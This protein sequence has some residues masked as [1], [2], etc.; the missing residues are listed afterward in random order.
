[1]SLTKE[2]TKY[3]EDQCKE[4]TQNKSNWIAHKK[5]F[6]KKRGSNVPHITGL[7]T[8]IRRMHMERKELRV[9]YLLRATFL[10]KQGSFFYHEEQVN[11]HEAL[12]YKGKFIE[13]K[14]IKKIRDDG[15][16]ALDNKRYDW[17]ETVKNDRF[18]YDRR[19]AVNYAERWWDDYNP[20]FKHF[21]VDCTNFVSQALYAGGA[22]MRGYPNRSKGWWY[23]N[24]TWSYSWAVAHSLRWYLSGSTQG[25]RGKELDDPTQLLP[26]D[27]I[28]Y[29]FEGDGKW[30]HNTIVVM[31]DQQ[32]MPLVNAHTNNSRHRYWSYEDSY[33]W[34]PKCQYKF[35]RIGD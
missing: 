18:V 8:L 30:D 31:K 17:I 29:D 13:D 3:W 24:N 21:D 4:I 27:I 5:Q 6:H 9:N 26:G 25:L 20:A 11:E 1:M 22:P 23:H 15:H 2:L 33:A 34:T 28:C 7:G 19:A 12:F 35:F 10:V 16:L 32:G 14:L